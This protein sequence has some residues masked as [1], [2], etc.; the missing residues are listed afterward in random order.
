MGQFTTLLQGR[1]SRGEFSRSSQ[2]HTVRRFQ[3]RIDSEWPAEVFGLNP[4]VFHFL[5][6]FRR[7]FAYVRKFA[8]VGTRERQIVTRGKIAPSSD[9]APE[10]S[11]PFRRMF[12]PTPDC[13]R[14]FPSRCQYSWR[15]L[16]HSSGLPTRLP[17]FLPHEE[18][19]SIHP[20]NPMASGS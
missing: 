6:I 15:R 8:S 13:L 19:G 5:D 1:F 17:V 4:E 2:C 9:I 10:R 14:R 3:D 16:P 12:Y 7:K 11:A 20:G 18:T